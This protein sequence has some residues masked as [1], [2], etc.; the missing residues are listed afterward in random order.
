MDGD[1]FGKYVPF[2]TDYM[3]AAS[4]HAALPF[5]SRDTLARVISDRVHFLKDS[6]EEINSLLQQRKKLRYE[7]Q[8]EIEN[9]TGRIQNLL[10]E[11]DS[12]DNV[13]QT[14]RCS[15]EGTIV[16]LSKERRNLELSHFEHTVMLKR[17]LRKAE[18]ELRT[19]MLDLWM[20]RFLS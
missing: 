2:S 12:M 11:L 5:E 14:E 16:G 3:P 20:I 15:L 18:R 4:T 17:D 10:F 8:A 19:A 7:L 1:F 13:N 9:N 6:I